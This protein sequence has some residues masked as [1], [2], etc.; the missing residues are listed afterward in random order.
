MK[1]IFNFEQFL[2][3]GFDK[4]RSDDEG[5]T[6]HPEI[7]AEDMTG[8]PKTIE[9]IDAVDIEHEELEFCPN[10]GEDW[11]YCTCGGHHMGEYVPS[12]EME[13]VHHEDFNF[14][15][16][17]EIETIEEKKKAKSKSYEESGLEH[18]EKADRNKNKRIEGWEER[19]GKA[20]EK[21]MKGKGKH[22]EDDKEDKKDD[23][24][25]KGLTAGQKK[26][27]KKLQ[28]KILANQK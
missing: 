4:Y 23:K 6:W 19:T 27:P 26:L 25:K 28:D 20:I 7:D 17:E 18:P 12:S 15:D 24:P 14:S 11:E 5:K 9:P 10:C 3:E 16:E 8:L 22:K 2:K 1:K 21:S 13:L